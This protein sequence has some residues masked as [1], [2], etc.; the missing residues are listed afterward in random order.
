MGDSRCRTRGPL[1]WIGSRCPRHIDGA[2]LGVN[3]HRPHSDDAI[4]RLFDGRLPRHLR[5]F[6]YC[7][8]A[9]PG[10]GTLASHGE[11]TGAQTCSAPAAFIARSLLMH[12]LSMPRCVPPLFEQPARLRSASHSL[13]TA[14]P[15]RC[16]R[17]HVSVVWPWASAWN[18][19]VDGWWQVTATSRSTSSI[20]RHRWRTLSPI[21]MSSNDRSRPPWSPA[22]DGRHSRC[23]SSRPRHCAA[24]TAMTPSLMTS[25]S[26]PLIPSLKAFTVSVPA[27]ILRSSLLTMPA[28]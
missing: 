27:V 3:A 23:A 4:V 2:D 24:F 25:E 6:D 9:L 26:R 10:I 7:S 17:R 20:R 13:A 5:R 28:W 15:A 12:V 21:A 19:D 11:R 14:A 22:S 18:P 1:T 16:H 8:L